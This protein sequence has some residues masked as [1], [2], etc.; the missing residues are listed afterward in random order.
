M[1]LLFTP[2]TPTTAFRAGEKTADPV[3]MYQADIFVCPAS[4]A[5]LPAVSLPIGRSAGLPVGGQL[6]APA[7]AESRLLACAEAL[8]ARLDPVAEVR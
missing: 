8:E 7:L 1:D 3:A 4:L 5:G 6:I 2:T